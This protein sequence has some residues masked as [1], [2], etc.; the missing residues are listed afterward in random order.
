MTHDSSGRPGSGRVA[1]GLG[2][3]LVSAMSFALSGPLARG[4]MDTGWT[5]AA[6][7]AVRVLLG[8]VAL[9]PVAL[10]ALRG[11]WA[12]LR[13]ALPL[14][15]GY[16]LVAV[17]GCQFTFFTAVSYLPVGVALLI[18]YTA[19]IAVVGWMWLRHAQ[20]PNRR[21]V[22]GAVLGM[23]GLV[24]VIDVG[25]GAVSLPGIAWAL[26]AMVGGAAYFIL[27]AR[28]DE[29]LPGVVLAAGALLVGGTALVAAGAVG[30]L[31]F[32]VSDADVVLADTAVPWWAPITALGIVT[33]A[34][35]YVAGIAAARRLGARLASF[36]ALTEVVIALVLA[37]LLLAEA[38]R[39]IQV[40][41]GVVV[42]AG[43][44]LVKLGERAPVPAE[45]RLPVPVGTGS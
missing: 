26:L 25:G 39:A 4:L 9:L 37:W 35:A 16:G 23:A 3:A 6:A 41:G 20:R 33:A 45:P 8:G 29:R 38:P 19:P 24:L 22:G 36:C 5:P 17:A 21:T 34:A 14:I 12:L 40:L 13:C 31:P 1:S 44:V 18:E 27:S 11:R 28:S 43:V 7:V 10:V 2:F 15:V 32:A 30:L 42:L